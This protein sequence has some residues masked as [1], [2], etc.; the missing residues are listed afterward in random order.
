MEEMA[1]RAF[2]VTKR[3]KQSKTQGK[4]DKI[5]GEKVCSENLRGK[6]QRK[7]IIAVVGELFSC[8]G[9]VISE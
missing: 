1:T 3:K 2:N 4:A 7:W 5:S 6:K 9:D 8:D